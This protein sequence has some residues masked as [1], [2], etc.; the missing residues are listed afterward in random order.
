MQHDAQ[1]SGNKNYRL[2]DRVDAVEKSV[3][4]SIQSHED[5]L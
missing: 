5:A 3:L 4:E 2:V 1:C